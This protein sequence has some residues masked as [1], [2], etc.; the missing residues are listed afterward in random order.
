MSPLAT[1]A[2]W[3]STA[4]TLSAASVDSSA[5]VC[6]AQCQD[7]SLAVSLL[8][9][10]TEHA[11]SLEAG[12]ATAA[13]ARKP[14]PL[15]T[16]FVDLDEPPESR[17][18]KVMDYYL[19]LGLLRPI[20]DSKGTPGNPRMSDELNARW[21]AAIAK[22]VPAEI[23][24]EAQGM[25]AY[26]KKRDP[27]LT[28]VNVET[29]LRDAFFY[30][31]NYPQFCSS[32]L[33]AMPNGTVMHGRNMDYGIT[34]PWMGTQIGWAEVTTDVIF[35]KSGKPLFESVTW[36]YQLGVHTG[37]RYDGWTYDQQTRDN[38][39]MLDN[40]AAI[41]AGA[42][43]SSF[44]VRTLMETVPDYDTA[45]QE[46][47]NAKLAAPQYFIMSG[48][49]PFQG[50]SM[51]VDRMGAHLPGSPPLAQ[52]NKDGLWHIVQTNDDLNRPAEDERRPFAESKLALT[53]QTQVTPLW[54]FEQM[55]A[56]P[57]FNEDTAFTWVASA[58]TNYNAVL[59][60]PQAVN[61]QE[62]MATVSILAGIL[63]EH[64]EVLTP[65]S[66]AAP[67]DPGRSTGALF[68]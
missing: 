45:V 40:L 18:N 2:L 3:L 12:H 65:P 46:L 57:L 55:R 25:A 9:M 50:T 4:A 15:P 20:E 26:V 7:E 16:F 51:A 37:V 6:D 60:P 8:Q 27:T 29:I 17:W 63:K 33:A 41:E 53:S 23:L 61:L 28:T 30:E 14:G 67:A 49:K 62:H 19:D 58:A 54:M 24:R 68:R 66:S 38:N 47:W 42:L 21:S 56:R 34:L 13:S 5:A 31:Q 48:S 22:Q 44:L 43:G 11:A 52:L 39:V 1:V 59:L 35:H 32:I 10:S 64:P 36:P